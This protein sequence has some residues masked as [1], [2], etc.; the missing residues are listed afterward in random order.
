[1]DG[2]MDG[3]TDGWKSSPMKMKGQKQMLMEREN[4]PLPSEGLILDSVK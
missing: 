3:W 2:W 4:F 1:M